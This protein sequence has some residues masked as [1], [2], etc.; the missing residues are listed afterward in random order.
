MHVHETLMATRIQPPH[1]LEWT[2][3]ECQRDGGHARHDRAN[4]GEDAERGNAEGPLHP[5]DTEAVAES[6]IFLHRA[7]SE[8]P[9]GVPSGQG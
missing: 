3:R 1:R 4:K 6:A 2:A 9:T 8:P 5:W 7:S